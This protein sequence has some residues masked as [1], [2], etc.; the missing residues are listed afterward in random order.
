MFTLV[1]FVFAIVIG[2]FTL[3]LSSASY[4]IDPYPS[5]F[6]VESLKSGS[7]A[8]LNLTR[9]YPKTN[10]IWAAVIATKI[11]KQ[12]ATA[13]ITIKVMTFL[14]ITS[15]G[16]LCHSFMMIPLELHIS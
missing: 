13:N 16:W 14:L 11:A 7:R 6:L 10:P 2:F 3:S 4:Y 12:V 15:L 9:Y 5:V 8:T 1:V